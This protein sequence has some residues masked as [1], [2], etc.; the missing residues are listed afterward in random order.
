V[1]L[2]VESLQTRQLIAKRL[3]PV[4]ASYGASDLD[5]SVIRSGDRRITK[6]IS[7]WAWA[8]MNDHG[9]ARYGG[10]RY[11]S[12]LNSDWEC[13]AVFD[14]VATDELERRS[15]QREMPE[16]QEVAEA[17]SLTVY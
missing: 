2:N 1:F 12:R 17:L 4:L 14:R 6:A 15:I 10:M 13:W 16:L 7:L 5:V 3:S 9:T 11:V 8:Q